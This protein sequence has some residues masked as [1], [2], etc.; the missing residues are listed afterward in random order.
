VTAHDD[1]RNVREG[2]PTKRCADQT[3][4]VHELIEALT[5]LGNYL[6]AAQRQFENRREMLGEALRASL[7]QYERAG[8]CLRGLR[9]LVLRE[10]SKNDDRS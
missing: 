6:F 5:A 9:D 2:A 7:G 4:L 8:E 10:G 3:A 1:P